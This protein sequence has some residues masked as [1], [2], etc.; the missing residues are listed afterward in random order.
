M[1]ASLLALAFGNFVIGTGT[2]I[3]LGMLPQLANGLGVSLSMAGQLITAFAVTVCL[4]APLLA[5]ATSRFDRRALLASMQLLFLFG[6]LAAALVSSFVPMLAVRIVTSIGAALFTAQAASTAALLVPPEQ[7]GRALAFVFL[8]W[9]VASVLG[10][11]LGAYVSA[12]FGWRAG[13]GLVATLAALGTAAV[14]AALP[15]DLKVRPVDGA[16]WRAILT[17]SRLLSVI[18]A[19]A[20][21]TAASFALF[22]YFVPAAH[23]FIDAS[24]GQVSVLLATL[25]MMSIIGNTLAARFMDRAGAGNVVV[26]CLATVAV[27]HLLWPLS[28]GHPIV[29]AAAVA[30]W[31]LG[32]VAGLSAQQARLAALAPAHAPVSI[33]LNSSATY[34]GQA[35]GA[36]AAGLIIAHVSGTAGYASLA[37]VSLPLLAGAIALSLFASLR[38]ARAAAQ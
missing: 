23:A 33:A 14:W 35:I 30:I 38:R 36:A 20:L 24:A 6:H 34:L 37:G 27:G 3:V 29:L 9:S 17:N 2:L 26:W 31:G 12:T 32:F 4:T 15:N 25:G 18:A 1:N 22:G 5:T 28:V 10:L 7:R 8:G 13:F 21:M 19:T 16:M 11:P